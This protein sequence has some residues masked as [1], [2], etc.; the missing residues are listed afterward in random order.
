MQIPVN[1]AEK[2][3][4]L[5]PANAGMRPEVDTEAEAEDAALVASMLAV[6][7]GP[8]PYD[9]RQPSG[10][11][12]PAKQGPKEGATEGAADRVQAAAPGSSAVQPTR[13]LGAH[14][15]FAALSSGSQPKDP[16]HVVAGYSFDKPRSQSSAAI[17]PVSNHAGDWI[18]DGP[19]GGTRRSSLSSKQPRR[20]SE[21]TPA[22][23]SACGVATTSSEDEHSWRPKVE[24]ED[25]LKVLEQ[26]ARFLKAEM[27]HAVDKLKSVLDTCDAD[28]TVEA[29]V[30]RAVD[31]IETLRD[32]KLVVERENMRLKNKLAELS[33]GAHPLSPFSTDTVLDATNPSLHPGDP[34]FLL[35]GFD[36]T[37]LV[38]SLLHIFFRLGLSSAI[39]LI[40]SCTTS[41]KRLYEQFAS[42]LVTMRWIHAVESYRGFVDPARV[43]DY[44]WS[45]AW[46]VSVSIPV[47]FSRINVLA[48]LTGTLAVF[49]LR[50]L[51]SLTSAVGWL[52][53]ALLPHNLPEKRVSSSS[54]RL[55]SRSRSSDPRS[56]GFPDFPAKILP[57]AD[58]PLLSSPGSVPKVVSK[59][60]V[61][62][63]LHSRTMAPPRVLNQGHILWVD[64]S[65]KSK[66]RSNS[67]SRSRSNSSARS[68]SKEP[69]TGPITRFREK[70]PR[71]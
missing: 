13:S 44:V 9:K 26:D 53:V 22:R 58:P 64:K 45:P 18:E 3:P 60:S 12:N 43:F 47:V 20:H 69:K 33:A 62:N 16:P 65:H 28:I 24:D 36:A 49:A 34:P 61:L 56:I 1:P 14:H 7:N 23:D 59:K 71:T 17:Q 29:I 5:M 4:L 25:R 32:S 50:R 35:Q 39:L 52:L 48:V 41:P 40:L 8:D 51:Q 27:Q 70:L 6:V 10:P 19:A 54:T 38:A 68:K 57:E 55:S 15:L 30:H 66:S 11:S 46:D 21:P 31:S 63:V 67:A 2:T 37:R 42:R